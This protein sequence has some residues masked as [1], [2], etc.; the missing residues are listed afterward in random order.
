MPLYGENPWLEIHKTQQSKN[1]PWKVQW[2][3]GPKI[4]ADA[5]AKVARDL[6]TSHKVASF[7]NSNLNDPEVRALLPESER[8]FG[9]IQ[10]DEWEMYGK[11]SAKG[12]SCQAF[13]G[14]NSIKFR[15]SAS[16]DKEHAIT[17]AARFLRE[18]YGTTIEDDLN[19]LDNATLQMI[20]RVSASD[21]GRAI[22]LF[23]QARLPQELAREFTDACDKANEDD[24]DL[25]R[26][27]TDPTV[28]YVNNEAV[29]QVFKYRTP[30]LSPEDVPSFEQFANSRIGDN[31][32][33]LPILESLF[34]E[35]QEGI[36]QG[37][38][39]AQQEQAP[40]EEELRSLS[41]GDLTSLYF[42]TLGAQRAARK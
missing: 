6:V 15:L 5:T 42:Q 41:D 16:L 19:D 33:S 20:Q 13:D 21:S 39:T 2:P 27:V 7:I 9:P 4:P 26:L 1:D 8:E 30:Q 23:M 12:W 3:T 25:I 32:L 14:T 10:V 24:S 31:A 18:K 22:I 29:Y 35:W 40:T 36:E 38:I 37:S 11:Q 34:Q 17:R 28:A